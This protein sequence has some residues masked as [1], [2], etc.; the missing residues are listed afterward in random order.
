MA[1]A[2]N[3]QPPLAVDLGHAPVHLL[4][5][6]RFGKCKIQLSEDR[7]IIR[8]SVRF[9]RDLRGKRP[10]NFLDLHL[11]RRNQLLQLV[12]DFDD[13]HRLD[14]HRRAG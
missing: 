10:E 12:A 3:V 6:R 1:A 4:G 7:Q 5:Q 14:E 2:H 13:G 9:R 8:D 11:F